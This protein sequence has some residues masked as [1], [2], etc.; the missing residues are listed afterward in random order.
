LVELSVLMPCHNE[1]RII[2]RNI[3]TTMDV[4][5]RSLPT[6]GS[7]EII[8]IDDGSTDST[9]TKMKRC[10]EDFDNVK[11]VRIRKNSGKGHALKEGFKH[12]EGRFV[13]FLDGDL[14]LHPSLIGQFMEQQRATKADVIIGSKRHPGSKINYPSGRRALSALYHG[15]VSAIFDLDVTDSQVGLKLFKREVLESV[16]PRLLVKRYAF[17]LELLINISAQG[18]TIVEAPIEMDFITTVGSDVDLYAVGRMLLDTCA[19]FYR[20]NVLHYYNGQG[21]PSS[22]DEK[23]PKNEYKYPRPHNKST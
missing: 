3:K 15:F 5:G 1:T 19:V 11:T 13:V 16:L 17:D 9:Y 12:A 18:Y 21:R 20:K 7:Y 22:N 8:A 23:D 6:P 10:V 2:R 14:D 4:L